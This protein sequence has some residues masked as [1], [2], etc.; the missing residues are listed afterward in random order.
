M[1]R[2]SSRQG[3]ADARSHRRDTS[4]QP[5][6]GG[7][8]NTDFPCSP[9]PDLYSRPRSAPFQGA[10]FAPPSV[11]LTLSSSIYVRAPEGLS[12]PSCAQS[13]PR[14]VC[15][16]VSSGRSCM[17][18][19]GCLRRCACSWALGMPPPCMRTGTARY[20]ARCYRRLL[21]LIASHSP[22][23]GGIEASPTAGSPAG[24]ASGFERSAAL[25]LEGSPRPPMSYPPSPEPDASPISGSACISAELG[26]PARPSPI[27]IGLIRPR[28]A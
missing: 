23:A 2:W 24:A 20:R 17:I 1:F 11:P 8:F 13:S 21:R 18:Q 4:Y 25:K 27:R 26:A 9:N 10:Q 12:G 22:P 15:A 19:S 6:I 28:K 14:L 7:T 16:Y 3:F 5:C